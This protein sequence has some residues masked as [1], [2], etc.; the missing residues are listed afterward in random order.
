MSLLGFLQSAT[1][2][3]SKLF[4]SGANATASRT[5][6]TRRTILTDNGKEFTDRLFGLRKRGDG[7]PR[8]RQALRRTGHRASPD[9]TEIVAGQRHGRTLQRS[10][11]GGASKPPL[12]LGRGTVN[13][14]APLRLAL[15]PAAPAISPGQQIALASDERLAQT[16]AKAVQETAILPS[17]M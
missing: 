2:R 5:A 7:G 16:E 1:G 17:G 11:R 15:Q 12:P 4:G 3:Q 13:H 9:P 8:I 10:D 6:A 14:V